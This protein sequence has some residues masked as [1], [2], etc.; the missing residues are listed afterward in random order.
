MKLIQITTSSISLRSFLLPFARH[1]RALGWQVDALAADAPECAEC[2]KAFDRVFH[3]DWSRNPLNPHNLLRAVRQVQKVVICGGYDIVHVHTPV[4]AFVTRFALRNLR[5][6]GKSKVIYTVHGFHFH[7]EGHPLKNH[8]FLALEKLVGHWTDYLVVINN[9]DRLAAKRH[10]IVPPEQIQYIPGI[11]VDTNHYTPESVSEVEVQR[12][13]ANLGLQ[14]EER[15]FL[16]VAEFNPGKRHQD[17]LQAFAKLGRKD[18]HLAFAGQGPLLDPM[19]SLAQQL[20]VA[21]QVH[22]LGFRQDIPILIRAS[23]ASLLPSEREG[24]SRSVMES[25]CLEV[26]VIGTNIRGVQDLLKGG[27]GLLVKVGDVE[28]LALAMAWMLD[29]PEEAREMGR[30]GRKHMVGYDLRHILRLHEELYAEVVR[31]R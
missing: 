4:A 11:G 20:G 24:L 12:V 30:R 17:T 8:M 6:K 21:E 27:C 7:R 5:K 31:R 28:G 25:L 18:V 13:R 15:L 9:E 2:R 26:P 23:L 10:R 3:V 29:H 22:F 14:P 19:R 16:M 1:F